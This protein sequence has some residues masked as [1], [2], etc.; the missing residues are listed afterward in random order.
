MNHYSY[1]ILAFDIAR[2]R[3]AEAEQYYLESQLA[4]AAPARSSAARRF[5]A[6]A[7]AQFS[8][9]SAWIVRKLDECVADD[10]GRRLSP[11]E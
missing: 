9:G 10:L 1:A 8:R 7:V 4:A 5:A 11:A 3:A 6:R 2:Q